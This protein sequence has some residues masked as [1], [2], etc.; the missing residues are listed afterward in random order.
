MFRGIPYA[1]ADRFERPTRI[2]EWTDELDATA[3][4]A[5]CPQLI[6]MV[7]RALGASSVPM[8]EHCLH[9]NVFTPGCDDRLRPVLVWLHG[10][11]FTTG[12][13]SMPWYDGSSLCRRGDVVVV[14]LNYRLGALGFAGTDNLGTRDQVAALEWVRDQ[15]GSFGGDPDNVTIFG[16]SAGG[17]AV[18]TLFAV[19]SATGLFARGMAMSPSVKQLRSRERAVEALEELCRAAGVGSLEDLRTA[20]LDQLLEAQAVLLR[21]VGAGFTGFSPCADGELIEESIADAVAGNPLPLLIGTTRDEMSL[22]TAFNPALAELDDNA[23]QA[24]F[25]RRFG[26][27]A[28]AAI[29][30]YRTARPGG[31]PKQLVAAMQTDEIFRTPAREVA[32]RRIAGGQP[33]WMY[34]F[35]WPT[36]AFGGV[37]GSCHAVDIPFAFDNLDRKGVA[38]FTGT[39]PTRQSV[40][41]TFSNAIIA[42]ARDAEPGWAAYDTAQRATLQI[43]VESAVLEDPEAELRRIWERA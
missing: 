7:E 41:D 19:A 27:G 20:S 10:G 40:A 30:A 25:V 11:A 34:W 6:G 17:A 29:A 39:D 3:Y 42:F 5:Q 35:T 18:I 22:F 1:H 9:L 31:T 16:E 14:T 38:E 37:L 23:M 43:D 2:T 36:P 15:I 21:D 28:A 4:G 24:M 33:T 13:G 32:E 8:D 26:E 12:S